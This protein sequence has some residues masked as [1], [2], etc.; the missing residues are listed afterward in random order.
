[1]LHED[2]V[3]FPYNGLF[4][5]EGEGGMSV[6]GQDLEGTCI[7]ALITTILIIALARLSYHSSSFSGIFVVFLSV[8]LSLKWNT[9]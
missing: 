4:E 2:T 8:E 9:P 1:M 5:G 6:W 7:V 3:V